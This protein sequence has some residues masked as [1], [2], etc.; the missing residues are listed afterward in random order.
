[1]CEDGGH[2]A[3]QVVS[4]VL[5]VLFGFG[6][7]IGVAE[8]LRRAHAARPAIDVGLQHRLSS[9]HN[10]SLAAASDL[11]NE[12]KIGSSYG[13][14]TSAY[15]SSVCMWESVDSKF[16]AGSSSMCGN[17]RLIRTN[18]ILPRRLYAVTRKLT[19][20]G[21]VLWFGR[22]SVLQL[23]SALFVA[24]LFMMAQGVVQ[25]FKLPLDNQLRLSTELHTVL[26]I[27]IASTIKADPDAQSNK[28]AYDIVMVVTCLFLVLLPFMYAVRAKLL[29]VKRALESEKAQEGATDEQKQRREMAILR[30]QLGLQDS[31]DRET[32]LKYFEQ[33]TAGKQLWRDKV[34]ASHLTADEMRNTLAK[35]EATLPKSHALGYHFTDLDSVN[36]V[37]ESIGIRASNVGQ[38]AGGVSICLTSP[39]ELGWSKFAGASFTEAVGKALWGSKWYEVM[40]G[41]AWPDLEQK[42]LANEVKGKWPTAKKEWGIWKKK[43]EA[44]FVVKIPSKD[45]IDSRRMVPGREDVFIIPKSDCVPDEKD[46]HFFYPNENILQCFILAAP[47]EVGSD[48][49]FAKVLTS[50]AQ[51]DSAQR[52]ILES[53]R[54]K[55]G[56]MQIVSVKTG[57]TTAD[58]DEVEQ[59]YVVSAKKAVVRSG[60]DPE[61]SLVEGLPKGAVVAAAEEKLVAGH[62]RV[63]VGSDRWVSKV[64]GKGKVLLEDLGP[65]KVLKTTAVVAQPP[66]PMDIVAVHRKVEKDKA[67]MQVWP[68][69]VTRFTN[70]EME[71]A[72]IAL[73]QALL[74]PYSLA[75]C[76]MIQATADKVC[77]K[78][79]GIKPTDGNRVVV[80]TKSP[81][82]L[83]WDKN[84]GD[85]FKQRVK[86]EVYLRAIPA[87]SP[88]AQPTGQLTVMVVAV[89][90]AV[91]EDESSPDRSWRTIPKDFLGGTDGN[92]YSN[93]HIQKC[94]QLGCE[95]AVCSAELQLP[96]GTTDA[97]AVD[98]D[99]DVEAP[100]AGSEEAAVTDV[101]ASHRTRKSQPAVT[102]RH[103]GRNMESPDAGT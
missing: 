48:S 101:I 16:A 66:K 57:G 100:S 75:Y 18:P 83:E 88:R 4:V 50:A 70:E 99:A 102:P 42:I 22:G 44:V 7:P 67:D 9:D 55:H 31:V 94:Y 40:A 64:T 19:L 103:F 24:I 29:S 13:F 32:M 27:L 15:R 87:A 54:D 39:V 25:P 45:N 97:T 69:D 10:L 47:D 1:M 26:I 91:L 71:C 90:T 37:L 59:Q 21:L 93:A 95:D 85:K 14:L 65:P 82:D 6:V 92:M 2:R 62:T 52:V 98:T 84:G 35:L 77:E 5:I 60:A 3:L 20:V 74:Q 51:G 12:I 33:P 43:L 53:T 78:G 86:N 17:A 72:L 61:S 8:F 49:D 63:R 41:E 73:D 36:L 30:F 34:I 80:C 89:P 79:G 96:L 68:E 46:E 11:I 76:Y 38:L 28:S 81:V 23:A 56:G 58:E